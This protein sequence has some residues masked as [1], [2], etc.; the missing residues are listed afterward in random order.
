MLKI[1]SIF[2]EEL[3][4]ISKLFHGPGKFLLTMR[5]PYSIVDIFTDRTSNSCLTL[6][7]CDPL[8]VGFSFGICRIINDVKFV[9]FAEPVTSSSH[10]IVVGIEPDVFVSVHKGN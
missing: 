5:K 1:R 7:L 4:F 6:T 2:S 3:E 10:L 8:V 9:L